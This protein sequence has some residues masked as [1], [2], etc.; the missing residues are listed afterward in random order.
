MRVHWAALF[1]VAAASSGLRAGPR[2]SDVVFIAAFDGTAQ[3]YVQVLPE[4]F[5]ATAAHDVL[6]ALHGHGS[7]RW[8]FVKDARDECRAARDFAAARGMIFISPDYRAKT[9][10]MGPA[11]EADVVQI[12]ELLRQTRRVGRLFLCGGSMGAS[13]ALTFAALHPDLA[14][15]VAAM[16]GTA[17]HL[18]YDNFQEAIQAAFGGTK[19]A[20]PLEYKRRSAEYWPERL[21]MPIGLT[22]GGADTSVPPGSVVRL[23]GVLE[24]IGRPVLLIHRPA[25]GHATSYADALRILEFAVDGPAPATRPAATRPAA[26]RPSEQR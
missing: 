13:A 11:A 19:T 16:N 23:A 15:G 21:T 17:N 9:S 26:T 3:R 4:P 8:Q 2:V 7:D 20:I 24:R 18:E 25:V 5:D 12:I 10:W 6:I 1:V 22:T 14:A